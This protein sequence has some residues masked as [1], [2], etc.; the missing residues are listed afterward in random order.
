MTSTQLA[1]QIARYLTVSD[2][3]LMP[4]P[5]MLDIVAAINGGLQAC[6][7]LLPRRYKTTTVS[8]TLGGPVTITATLPE[9]F[10]TVFP[11]EPPFKPDQVGC[12]CQLGDDPQY[13]QVAAVDRVLD[14]YQ[15]NGGVQ[16]VTIYK[17]CIQI[18]DGVECISS[19]VR[20]Y[21]GLREFA[22][23]RRQYDSR[24]LWWRVKRPPMRPHDYQIEPAGVASGAPMS[25]LMRFH[26]MPN[27]A[28]RIRCEADISAPKLSFPNILSVPIKMPVPER[29]TDTALVPL[30]AQA[31]M[32]SLY[33]R[34]PQMRKT[35]MDAATAA[36]AA[37]HK[38][39]GDTGPGNN[40]MG[41]PWGF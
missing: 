25:F 33:W 22:L 15:G 24:G 37:I 16:P 38:L 36:E 13:N 5:A 9:P 14:Q 2:L 18:D 29:L 10:S 40:F 8:E 35:V 6:Y 28:Y 3:A 31:L 32:T 34:D 21:D 30:C 4:A 41:T 17:D 7:Q 23:T 12:T 1:Q 20:L 39:D 11:G 26:P 19:D 27:I